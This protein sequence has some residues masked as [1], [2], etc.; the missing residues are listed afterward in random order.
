MGDDVLKRTCANKTERIAKLKKKTRSNGGRTL[1]K[2]VTRH[3]L[4]RS[5][6]VLKEELTSC[7]ASPEPWRGKTTP[8]KTLQ[9]DRAKGA[10]IGA[11]FQEWDEHWQIGQAAQKQ[12][13][14][15]G[16]LELRQLEEAVPPLEA[17]VLL[18]GAAILKSITGWKS[19]D[20]TQRCRWIFPK[21]NKN[22]L[23]FS[24]WWRWRACGQPVRV[25]PLS[26]FFRRGSTVLLAAWILW[27][28]C[29]VGPQESWC[30]KCTQHHLECK[31]QVCWW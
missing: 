2:P 7:T 11:M 26:F 18:K 14:P 19:M 1:G 22:I 30:G 6:T 16:C 4:R 27:W 28:E 15:W 17:R 3:S 13:R 29:L 12:E 10:R 24:I 23:V 8:F 21:S 20:S 5:L 9:E 31:L 25:P